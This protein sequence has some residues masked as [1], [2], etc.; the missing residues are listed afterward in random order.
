LLKKLRD[1][2]GERVKSTGRARFRNGKVAKVVIV[3]VRRNNH[4]HP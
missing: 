1:L 3:I 2:M 4:A